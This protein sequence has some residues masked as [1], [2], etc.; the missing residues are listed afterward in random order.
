MTKQEYF[1][2][3]FAELIKT[4]A[5]KECI[6][7]LH[8]TIKNQNERIE[9]LE[10]KMTLMEKYITYLEKGVDDQEQYN[11]R[12]CLRIDGIATEERES[13]EKC[14]AKVKAVFAK[15]DVDVP[16]NVIDRA[17]RI[18][19]PKV[20][21]GKNVHTMIVR[22]TTWRHRTAVYRARKNCSSYKIRLDLTKKRLDTVTRLSQL[23]E[24][25]KLGFVFADV[26]CRLCARINEKFHYFES[27][28]EL[29]EII[30]ETVSNDEDSADDDTNTV[31]VDEGS[32]DE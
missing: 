13:G 21:K 10:S 17:H 29:M 30:Q 22:F 27:E 32:V 16:E 25:R 4:M 3:K 2:V 20:V 7:T 23:L 24:S 26:N 31:V 5:T 28:D 18:G 8:E 15:L 12:L 1:D 19:K 11:R 6:Q 9:I 14:L